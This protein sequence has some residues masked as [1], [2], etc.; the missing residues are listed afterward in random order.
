MKNSTRDILIAA[1][2]MAAAGTLPAAGFQ[3][4]PGSYRTSWLGNSFPGDGGPNGFGYWVQNGADEIEVSPDGT[5]IAGTD[6][7]EAGRCVGLYKDGQVN[8]GLVKREGG[9]ETAWGWNTGNRALAV[10]G[11]N[12]FVA[13]TGQRLLRFTWTPGELDSAKFA[14]EFEMPGQAVGLA[15]R[16]GTLAVAYTN[17]VEL[18][19]AT[20]FVALSSV[21]VSGVSDVALAPDGAVWVIASNAVRRVVEAGTAGQDAARDATNPALLRAPV[22]LCPEVAKSTAISFAPDGRLIVCDDGADQQVKFYDVS[23]PQP[24]L[25][26]EFGEK[27]GLAAAGGSVS[28]RRLFALRGAGTDTAGNLYVA[29]GFS[30]GPQGNLFLRSF[31]PAGELR[32]E[33]HSAAFVDGY[34]FDADSDGRWIYGRTTIWEMDYA[35]SKPGKEATLR[36]ISLD[37]VTTPPEDWRR[38]DAGTA[39]FRQIG[40]RPTLLMM[41][42]LAC[43]FRF[44]PFARDSRFA[45][46]GGQFLAEN[47]WAWDVEPEGTL[48]WGDAP[49]RQIRRLPFGDW[50][51]DGSIA[52]ATNRSETW[53]WPDDFDR[54][55]RVL[56]DPK[57][58]MLFLWGYPKGTPEESWGVIGFE[59]RRYDGWRHGKRALRWRAAMPVNATGSEKG[60]PLTGKSVARAGDYL[61]VGMVKADGPGQ[62][63]VHIYS[64][65]T[66][67]YVGSL[68][69]DP[70]VVGEGV[71]WI[72][73]VMGVQAHRRQDGEY[74]VLVEEDWR[75]KNLLYRWKPGAKD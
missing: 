17:R 53:P 66:G 1:L 60:G 12:L 65:A 71:G 74:L 11:T 28:P 2:A 10:D 54:V 37:P 49:G 61:F 57:G 73:M 7:D 23:Q 42:M 69:P 64:Q 36:A 30:G 35:Q 55:T 62:H 4:P 14:E 56:Y 48:W 40:G 45:R 43:G 8:R 13:N 47:A 3:P 27:G 44:Y 21:P 72:D 67:D 34:G 58:D 41:N 31:T 20:G 32:W 46:P 22:S 63:Y 26:G 75:G 24:R 9:R 59:A 50:Q 39:L 18:R 19:R 25:I 29:M 70:K 51:P 16:A 15:A 52:Y 33:L 68:S 5:V 6:W 38:K